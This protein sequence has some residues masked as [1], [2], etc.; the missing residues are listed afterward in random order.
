MGEDLLEVPKLDLK[1]MKRT[2]FFSVIILFSAIS[3]H[4]FGQQKIALTSSDRQHVEEIL[5]KKSKQIIQII[6][7]ANLRD[8]LDKSEIRKLSPFIINKLTRLKL[9]YDLKL[10]DSDDS[11]V[12]VVDYSEEITFLSHYQ[13]KFNNRINIDH[14]TLIPNEID[15]INGIA[16]PNILEN[17]E[18][19]SKG[20]L[21]STYIDRSLRINR[22]KNN[23]VERDDYI[24]IVW[25]IDSRIKNDKY[26]FLSLQSEDFKLIGYGYINKKYVSGRLLW[27]DGWNQKRIQE[28][29]E[30]VKLHIEQYLKGVKQL[31]SEELDVNRFIEDYYIS[32]NDA[33][34]EYY[35]E[36]LKKTLKLSYKDHAEKLFENYRLTEE[37]SSPSLI[38]INII[39]DNLQPY[40]VAKMVDTLQ[41]QDSF[42][43]MK[44]NMTVNLRYANEIVSR[45]KIS[46]VTLVSVARYR[47]DELQIQE[48]LANEVLASMTQNLPSYLSLKTRVDYDISE[49]TFIK[50]VLR[51]TSP[52][53]ESW[54]NKL[55]IKVLRKNHIVPN[56]TF[57]K[58]R[59]GVNNIKK[60]GIKLSVL[61][62]DNVISVTDFKSFLKEELIKENIYSLFPYNLRELGEDY[63]ISNICEKLV[64]ALYGIPISISNKFQLVEEDDTD[65]IILEEIE[66]RIA[67]TYYVNKDNNKLDQF[68]IE[69][70]K[71]KSYIQFEYSGSLLQIDNFI[72]PSVVSIIFHDDKLGDRY[73]RIEYLSLLQRP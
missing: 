57:S 33:L 53:E 13:A 50:D 19:F 14:P 66:G 30:L 2:K 26:D 49:M 32:S 73:I 5:L 61:A 70:T 6:E 41:L 71:K 11:C 65:W 43:I 34:I 64:S 22:A 46:E 54:L 9:F 45:P 38:G 31:E 51:S 35:D 27:L 4:L 63:G 12:S 3:C 8:G 15:R 56:I 23:K 62:N 36:A 59:L 40:G 69:N 37:H 29:K 52:K 7:T 24:N 47:T 60:L 44:W 28:A 1:A 20:L 18:K 16:A 17:R 10:D 67:I 48:K 55:L 39:R 72:F 58:N 68:R 21:I 42:C 25:F